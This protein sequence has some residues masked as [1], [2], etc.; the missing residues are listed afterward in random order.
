MSRGPARTSHKKNPKSVKEAKAQQT[1][2][3]KRRT[4]DAWK[5]GAVGADECVGQMEEA[6]YIV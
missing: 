2:K 4:R 1:E 6:I 5:K 3:K